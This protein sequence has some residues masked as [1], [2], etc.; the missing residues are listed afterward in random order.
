VNVTAAAK[1]GND[2]EDLHAGIYGEADAVLN[3]IAD[4]DNDG[5]KHFF[6][7]ETFAMRSV[8]LSAG[9]KNCFPTCWSCLL[10]ASSDEV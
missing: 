8:K 3:I 4:I 7:P 6:S 10:L 1:L 2:C 9:K 5:H